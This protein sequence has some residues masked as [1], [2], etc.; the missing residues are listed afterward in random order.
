MPG[1]ATEVV[2]GAGLHLL[3]GGIDPHVHL[4]EPG[5]T[6]WEGVATGTAALAVGGVTSAIDMPLNASPPVLDGATF[7]LKAAAVQRS[8]RVDL[9][10]WGGLVPGDVDRLDE[11]ADARRRRLQ[12][13]HVARGA[14]RLPARRRPHAV[15]GDDAR[16]G[17]RAAGRGPRRE[18]RDHR[19]P[20]R[21]GAGR[22]AHGRARLPRFASDRRRD[23]SDR[24]CDPP[25]RR[26]RVRAARRARLDGRRRRRSS[27]T[28]ARAAST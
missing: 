28:P 10:L 13:V 12:G 21:T 6:E 5:R 3:P 11:L 14:G 23:G 9:A 1:D 15:R 17:A 8:A 20:R 7:D 19:R 16:R 4:N 2:D 22:G 27:P 18:R 24:A 25:G 26:D